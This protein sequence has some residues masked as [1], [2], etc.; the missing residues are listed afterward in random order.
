MR[1]MPLGL[2]CVAEA[3]RQAGHEVRI[4]DLMGA[5]GAT[6]GMDDAIDQWK[7]EAVGISLRNI[8]DQNMKSPQLFLAE[9]N[10]I[11][12]RVK[13][14]SSAPVILGGAGYSIFPE[15]ILERSS[16]DMGIW[17]EGEAA[18]TLLLQRLE[19]RQSLAGIPGL[20]VRAKGLQGERTFV[21]D[22]DEFPLP[23]T[24]LLGAAQ[25]SGATL[26][27]QTRRGCPL[28]CAYCSTASIEG[29]AVRSRPR[30][31]VVRWIA[32][33]AERHVRQLYF[34]DNTFNLPATYARDLCRDLAAASLGVSW[35]SIIYPSPLEADLAALM[36]EAGCTEAS[37]GFES[38]C[39]RILKAMNKHF[40]LDDIR[41]T[42]KSL[43]SAGIKC[44]GFLLLG[45]PGETRD[46]VKESLAFADSLDL[47]SLKVTIG[48]RIYPHTPL[49]RQ[50]REEGVI[51][52]H[53]DLLQ[54][55][56]YMAPGIEDWSRER[57]A[58]YAEARPKW[59]VDR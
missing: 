2:A 11:I 57:V 5:A 44:M 53:D 26:P 41:Q 9:A 49:A 43:R 37:I 19:S 17:G 15:A 51:P 54:P 36:A 18:F 7:P 1:T 56:F 59:I 35:R 47:D 23:D 58:E 34:V 10:G 3:A 12:E 24:D 45:G 16:A 14:F 25:E 21:T 4:L 50:A 6:D 30:K 8:D 31:G 20:Y 29:E 52:A 28:R 55:R 33:W 42:R 22:F 38:G 46:S 48:V 32:R 13:S 27:V 40:G 39:E